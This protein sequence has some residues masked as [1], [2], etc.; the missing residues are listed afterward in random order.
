M[1]FLGAGGL[2]SPVV[3][4]TENSSGNLSTPVSFQ[5]TGMEQALVR[6]SSCFGVLPIKARS[7]LTTSRSTLTT[8][9]APRHYIDRMVGF[10][11]SLSRQ[12]IS[13]LYSLASSGKANTCKFRVSSTLSFASAGSI[14]KGDFSVGP[15]SSTGRLDLSTNCAS[16]SYLPLLVI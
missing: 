5:L 1:S 2:G 11:L 14:M 4:V 7:N 6:T 8:G 16:K 9:W 13:S 12:I 10:G 15:P 3:L